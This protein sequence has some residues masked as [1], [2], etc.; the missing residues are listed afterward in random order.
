MTGLMIKDKFNGII[1]RVNSSDGIILAIGIGALVL[2]LLVDSF[3]VRLVCLLIVVGAGILVYAVLHS[4]RR[5]ADAVEE[6]AGPQYYSQ[7]ENEE[8]KK[9]TFDDFQ[10]DRGEKYTAEETFTLPV[11]ME[12]RK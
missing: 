6:N 1:T 10:S 7:S 9:L 3:I 4:K 11:M 5:D 2:G 8:M 12:A